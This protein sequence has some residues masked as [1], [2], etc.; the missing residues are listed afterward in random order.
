MPAT[1][2]SR[3]HRRQQA[4]QGRRETTVHCGQMEI[5]LITYQHTAK[6]LLKKEKENSIVRIKE[7]CPWKLCQILVSP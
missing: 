2:R 1:R 6:H 3:R 5:K 4:G 7:S